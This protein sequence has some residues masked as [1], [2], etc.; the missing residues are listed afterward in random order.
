M[1]KSL[2]SLADD[3][4]RLAKK[5]A[6]AGIRLT[7]LEAAAALRSPTIAADERC[8]R[9]PYPELSQ[10]ASDRRD[11]EHWRDDGYRTD[12]ERRFAV[13]FIALDDALIAAEAKIERRNATYTKP[14]EGFVCFHCGERFIDYESAK[15]HFGEK[16]DTQP[17]CFAAPSPTI[18]ALEPVQ[19]TESEAAELDAFRAKPSTLR[20]YFDS[21]PPFFRD[22]VRTVCDDCFEIVKEDVL[23]IAADAV[24][25]WCALEDC[26]ECL[27]RRK[28][29]AGVTTH[30]YEP[31]HDYVC[32]GCPGDVLW[33]SDNY[34]EHPGYDHDFDPIPFATPSPTIAIAN[35]YRDASLET[36]RGF[37]NELER[38]LANVIALSENVLR[39]QVWPHS[40]NSFAQ[41]IADAARGK[42]EATPSPTIAAPSPSKEGGE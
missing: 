30:D 3:L 6:Y 10:R 23:T 26:K 28:D 41:A 20:E 17:T 12:E 4:E 21:Y 35:A 13:K 42:Q 8:E 25:G 9:L 16:P 29:H 11:A 33:D 34:T 40:G 36:L 7:L 38:R 22:S 31:A 39:G 32:A 1:D 19:L 24:C 14:G 27:L 15:A 18:A 5:D 2:A 37:A